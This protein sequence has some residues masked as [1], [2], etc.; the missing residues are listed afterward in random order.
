MTITLSLV[1]FH[2]YVGIAAATN[3]LMGKLNESL[4]ANVTEEQTSAT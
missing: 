1:F 2:W 3:L 4:Y